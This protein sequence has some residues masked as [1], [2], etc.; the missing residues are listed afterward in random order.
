M[1][2][3]RR[4]RGGWEVDVREVGESAR[5]SMKRRQ[6]GD[7]GVDCAAAQAI[8]TSKHTHSETTAS[9]DGEK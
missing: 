2:L 3:E 7:S 5:A 6:H 4:R 8:S 9:E 1:Q